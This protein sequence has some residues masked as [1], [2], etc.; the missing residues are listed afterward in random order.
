VK[1]A[2]NRALELQ[3]SEG[4]LTDYIKIQVQQMEDYELADQARYCIR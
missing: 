4:M 1:I 3:Y 2:Q